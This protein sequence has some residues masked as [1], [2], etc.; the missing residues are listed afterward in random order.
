MLACMMAPEPEVGQK[1]PWPQGK[2]SR[3][4]GEMV[5]EEPQSGKEGGLPPGAAG[6]APPGKLIPKTYPPPERPPANNLE[7]QS[8]GRPGAAEKPQEPSERDPS[9]DTG[10]Q[11][12]GGPVSREKRL[13]GG[14]MPWKEK[15]GGLGRPKS[16]STPV[17]PN[18]G[19]WN[20]VWDPNNE[21]TSGGKL[22]AS[23]KP[24]SSTPG[25]KPTSGTGEPISNER[26]DPGSG[27]SIQDKP[28]PASAAGPL[29]HE[30]PL[31]EGKPASNCG[32]KG[33]G[34][35]LAGEKLT[36]GEKPSSHLGHEKHPSADEST[37]SDKPEPGGKPEAEKESKPEKEAEE[38]NETEEED[39]FDDDDDEQEEGE[40]GKEKEEGAAERNEDGDAAFDKELDYGLNKSPFDAYSYHDA[41]SDEGAGGADVGL[42]GETAA[43]PEAGEANNDG[44]PI[45]DA[46]G[47]LVGGSRP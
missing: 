24:T 23:E 47:D 44:K 18:L 33:P 25:D 7:V 3:E 42:R 35:P 36:S 31:P 41:W 15:S 9:P 29:T 39:L 4:D 12:G 43:L 2:E 16:A 40:K 27:H 26:P 38:R 19:T 11:R 28:K 14:N 6:P 20:P 21:A 46:W 13:P 45:F 5:A 30:G 8:S 22:N 1:S 37:A 10:P 17:L 32:P 34:R